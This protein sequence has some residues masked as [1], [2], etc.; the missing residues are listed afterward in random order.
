MSEPPAP[1]V[2]DSRTADIAAI[3]TIYGHHVVHGVASFEDAPPDGAEMTG[4]GTPSWPAILAVKY[5]AKVHNPVDK[6]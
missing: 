4:S 3:Q 2:R 5:C 1:V 6:Q